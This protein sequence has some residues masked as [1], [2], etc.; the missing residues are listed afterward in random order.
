MN[1]DTT[2]EVR[3]A[4]AEDAAALSLL[5]DDLGYPTGATVVAE[6]IEK[7]NR[8]GETVLVLARGTEVLGFVTVHVTPVLHRPA[9][10]GRM[11]ALV[12][13]RSARGQGLGRTLVAAAEQYL[14]RAGCAMV[15]VTSNHKRPDAHAFYQRLGYEMTSHRFYKPLAPVPADTNS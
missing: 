3:A 9:P 13:S 4:R 11:T 12:I 5:L 2:T 1:P 7:L 14:A 15:E 10:V 8:A 6:R